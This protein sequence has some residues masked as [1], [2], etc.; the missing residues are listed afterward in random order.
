MSETFQP[1]SAKAMR[2]QV[3]AIQRLMRAVMKEGEHYG[4]IP[5]TRKPSLWKPGAEKLCA[6]FQIEPSFVVEDLSTPEAY[7]YRVKCIGSRTGLRLGE[8]MGSCS[9][10]EQRYRWRKA[11]DEEFDAAP[12]TCR[13]LKYGYSPETR[14]AYELKQVRAEHHDFEN[15]ILKMACKRAHVAMVLNVTAASDIFAQDIEDLPEDF[16]EALPSA[17]AVRPKAISRPRA[18]KPVAPA[19]ASTATR[20]AQAAAD[21][22]MPVLSE[23]QQ[24]IL[25][26]RLKEANLSERDVFKK[27]GARFEGLPA[28]RFNDLAAWIQEQSYKTF[29]QGPTLR[30]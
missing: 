19:S 30:R 4:R 26:Q 25:S 10:L 2:A 14:R 15:T 27:F 29:M 16:I 21:S 1:L 22:E 23:G 24:R 3:D 12:E 8:G 9:S 6:A 28:A 7:R 20:A 5:G 13:R 11:S 17:T 18:K